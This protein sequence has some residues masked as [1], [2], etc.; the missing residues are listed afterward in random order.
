MLIPGQAIRD[1]KEEYIRRHNHVPP[2]TAREKSLIIQAQEDPLSV[3]QAPLPEPVTSDKNPGPIQK[4]TDMADKSD[5]IL[6][7]VS[8][9]WPFTL[10]VHDIIIDPYKVNVIFREFFK[11]E[12]IHSIMIKDITDIFIETSIFFATVK[13]VDLGFVENTVD[14]PYLKKDDALKVRKIV[15]GLVIAQKQS[16]DMSNMRPSD[17]KDKTEELGKVKGVDDNLN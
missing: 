10:F 5:N 16:I 3:N 7:K 8:T 17:I 9:T 13:I 15:Q 2:P 11:S 12:R 6:L 4:L 14:I 1:L